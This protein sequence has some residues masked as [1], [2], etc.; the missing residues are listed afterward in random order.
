MQV[1]Q[2]GN[3]ADTIT[4]KTI[5]PHPETITLRIICESAGFYAVE[6]DSNGKTV[7]GQFVDMEG[8]QDLYI[9][10]EDSKF[11]GDQANWIVIPNG[12]GTKWAELND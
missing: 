12:D 9:E 6:Y 1:K 2:I 11:Y 4:V 8:Q 10:T 7:C 3:T 5:E